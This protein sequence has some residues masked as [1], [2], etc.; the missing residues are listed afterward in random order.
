M[1]VAGRWLT[2][3]VLGEE[4]RAGAESPGEDGLLDQ[5]AVRGTWT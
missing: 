2:R 1:V 3:V 4:L 5:V